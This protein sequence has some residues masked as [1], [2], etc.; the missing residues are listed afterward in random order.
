MKRWIAG[1]LAAALLLAVLPAG[2]QGAS[3]GTLAE[4]LGFLRDM[5]QNEDVRSLIQIQDVQDLMTEV[6]AKV[7]IWM[8][9]NRPVTMEILKEL[10][11]GEADLRC[12]GKVWDSAERIGEAWQAYF[13]TE[14]GRR[15]VAEAK[16]V[17]KDPEL[18]EALDNFL[19]MCSQQ[20]ISGINAAISETL[21]K[22]IEEDLREDTLTMDTMERHINRSTLI[23]S[24]LLRLTELVES[25][26][27]AQSSLPKLKGNE[28]LWNLIIHLSEI[29]WADDIMR[30]EARKLTE[31]PEIND[32][33]RRT[34][35]E[36]V[37][38]V[39]GLRHSGE[40]PA[41]DGESGGTAEE[42]KP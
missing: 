14:D 38:L 35:G 22:G 5:I 9:Q 27:W 3:A 20:E 10:G 29:D 40:E 39:R 41:K 23:G 7:L 11:V 16:A 42:D 4:N 37:N 34:A 30:E 36:L 17:E 2:A 1:I 33:V 18:A 21:R 13:A 26:E 19:D 24:L 32:F 8:V 12:V 28:N 25:S 6:V 15:L 31:D